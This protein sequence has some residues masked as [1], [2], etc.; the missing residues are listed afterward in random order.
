MESNGSALPKFQAPFPDPTSGQRLRRSRVG[1]IY[2]KYAIVNG[3]SWISSRY[4]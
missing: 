2:Q 1:A 4:R 3:E